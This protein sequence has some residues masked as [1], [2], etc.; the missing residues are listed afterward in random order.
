MAATIAMV[1]TVVMSAGCGSGESAGSS[2]EAARAR[3]PQGGVAQFVVECAPSHQA[4]DDPIVWPDQP[5]ASHLHEFFGNAAVGAS[6]DPASADG[7]ATSCDQ[8]RDTASYW[9]PALLS[10]D[11]TRVEPLELVAYYRPA[12]GIDAT[13]LVAYPPG[14]MM[15]AGDA[16]ADGPQ[17]TDVVGWTCGTGP[18]RAD[19]PPQCPSGSSLRLVV[20]FPD[21]WDGEQLRLDGRGHDARQEHV[22]ASAGA[23][24]ASHPVA[25]P[26]LEVAI[27]YPP[28]DPS[29]LSFASGPIHTA[30]ADF[31]NVWD[32]TAL[33][34]E[35]DLCLRAGRVCGVAS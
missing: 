18:T 34:D 10:A 28:V 25:L 33:E 14:L 1:V 15:I 23:C 19:E 5:G 17:S 13:T 9:A 26:Q 12:P 24:P 27:D 2:V 4:F 30:H 32:Q 7:A 6:P 29:G 3:G 31:W 20:T 22:V 16:H 35:V 11:G 21:C 8:P